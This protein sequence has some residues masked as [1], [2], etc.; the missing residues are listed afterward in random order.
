[1]NIHLEKES[2]VLG[3]AITKAN[4]RW[5]QM[6]KIN[7]EILYQVTMNHLKNMLESKIISSEEYNEFIEKFKEKYSP[8]ISGLF[9][10][11]AQ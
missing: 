11:K 3:I 10:E 4:V 1:M 7:N 2:I 5:W 6:M 8:K 9:F